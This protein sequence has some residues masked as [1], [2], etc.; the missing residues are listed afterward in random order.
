MAPDFTSLSDTAQQ[1]AQE[2][3]AS[4]PA[5]IKELLHYEILLALMESGS[6]SGLVF[7]GGTALRLCYGGIGYSEDLDFAGGLAFEPSVMA[8][9]VERVKGNLTERYGLNMAVGIL[10]P[11]PTDKVPLGRWKAT[12]RLPQLARSVKQSYFIHIEVAQ[13]PAYSSELMP[14]RTLSNSVPSAY[15]SVLLRTE[16]K[17]EILAD[18]IVA[19]GARSYVKQRDLWDLHML[20]QEGV[21]L[22]SNWV[23]Q[24][25]RDYGLDV[26]TFL[27]SLQSR[28]TYLSD[29]AAESAFQK[30]MLRFLEGPNRSL[31]EDP[32]V[33]RQ[34]LATTARVAER[35]LGELVPN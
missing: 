32:L 14:L 7:Q 3:Q 9:F 21:S 8:P 31:I 17:E 6:A 22:N 4:L 34:I 30:E 12:V 5:V 20:A 33:V 29:Q 15:R 11:D 25:M 19:L 1:I 35:A 13:V 2:R 24:K 27:V 28:F 16:S 26:G 18:K 10:L 23:Q